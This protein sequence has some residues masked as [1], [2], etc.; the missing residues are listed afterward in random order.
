MC[1]RQALN[2]HITFFRAAWQ[3]NCAGSLWTALS[4]L[5]CQN[6]PCSHTYTHQTDSCTQAWTPFSARLLRHQM[7]EILKSPS[8]VVTITVLWDRRWDSSVS[9]V[10]PD[11]VVPFQA[12]VLV[13]S[14]CRPVRPARGTHSTPHFKGYRGYCPQVKRPEL[15]ADRYPPSNTVFKNV[16]S[17]TTSLEDAYVACTGT[18]LLTC[19]ECSYSF[20][21]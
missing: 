5:C 18:S 12:P 14:L 9:N 4:S 20:V 6:T 8:L 21:E 15:A 11:I 10:H 16:W 1:Q 13:Y 17:C 3:T 19:R 2:C 7:F